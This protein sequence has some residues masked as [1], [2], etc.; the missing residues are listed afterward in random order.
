MLAAA[1]EI[2][3]VLLIYPLGLVATSLPGNPA[4]GLHE[5]ASTRLCEHVAVPGPLD[6]AEVLAGVRHQRLPASRAAGTSRTPWP[7]TESDRSSGHCVADRLPNICLR[8][9]Q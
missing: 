5:D 6:H 3:P 9:L 2:S 1:L 4:A 7:M 8:R